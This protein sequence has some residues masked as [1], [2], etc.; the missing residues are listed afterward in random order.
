MTND[1]PRLLPHELWNEGHLTRRKILVVEGPSDSRFFRAWITQRFSGAGTT[2]PLVVSTEEID[3]P[4]DDLIMV[5]LPDGARS[6]VILASLSAAKSKANVRCVADLDCGHHIGKADPA[7]QLWTD[8]PSLESYAFK[9]E[10]LDYLNLMTFE[11]RL[12]AGASIVTSTVGLLAR[13]YAYRS[14]MEDA[15]NP[16]IAAGITV[17]GDPASFDLS[18]AL[19]RQLGSHAATA[20]ASPSPF[21]D[22]REVAY[23]HDIARALL[24]L[25]ANTFKNQLHIAD[26][27]TLE[28]V[29]LLGVLGEGSFEAEVLFRTLTIWILTR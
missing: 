26:E 24:A 8:Y 23:G 17:A 27:K 1:R 6:R 19:P 13:T 14:A 15:P 11:E 4:A 22:P 2:P 20:Q 5:G 3:I 12:P 10:V 16:D 21:R 28:R 18:A 7:V 25:Y 9:S 29:F